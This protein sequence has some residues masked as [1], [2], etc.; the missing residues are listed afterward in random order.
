MPSQSVVVFTNEQLRLPPDV[1]GLIVGR[2]STYN[3]GL[4]TATSYLDSGWDGLVKLHLINTSQRPL[5]LYLGME[6]ARLFLDRTANASL[7]TS[8]VGQQGVHFGLTWTRILDDKIDPFPQ[9]SSPRKW[10]LT[11]GVSAVNEL[12][13]RYAGL[14]LIA[15]ALSGLGAAGKVY[16]DI[17]DTLSQANSLRQTRDAVTEIRRALVVSGAASVKIPRGE[18]VATSV[19]TVPNGSLYRGRQSN[20]LVFLRDAPGGSTASATIE[21]GDGG[22]VLLRISVQLK[23]PAQDL[24]DIIVNWTYLP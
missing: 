22:R 7:D 18:Q 2:V 20:G 13:Q 19:V 12:L 16:I 6:I 8:R 11:T 1:I 5:R 15:L 23:H 9:A 14:G 4:V 24:L 3:N 17:R 10:R 21:Q